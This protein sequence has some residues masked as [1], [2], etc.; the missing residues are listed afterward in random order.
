[1]LPML[2][3]DLMPSAGQTADQSLPIAV[4]DEQAHKLNT[5]AFS[6]QEALSERATPTQA[7]LWA[8]STALGWVCT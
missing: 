7:L 5:P 3:P 8:P 6:F 1:M 2:P 4:T